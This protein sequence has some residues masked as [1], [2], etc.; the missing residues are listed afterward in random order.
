[1]IKGSFEGSGDQ[2]GRSGPIERSASSDGTAPIRKNTLMSL[3]AQVTEFLADGPLPGEDQGVETI[4]RA[5]KLLEAIPSPVTD[6]GALALLAGFGP[7]DCF[8]LAWT[9][10]HLVETAPG[11]RSA[12]Y[13]ADTDNPWQQ[14]RRQRVENTQ[15]ETPSTD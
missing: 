6:E 15:G 8:G 2:S 1:M 12:H 9:L 10:L 14:L 5:Q 13:P 4:E 7:D 3:R 11:A